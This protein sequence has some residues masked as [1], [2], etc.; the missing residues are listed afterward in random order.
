MPMLTELKVLM[1]F[2]LF[3][4]KSLLLLVKTARICDGIWDSFSKLP[5]LEKINQDA[6]FF[7]ENDPASNSIEEVYLA[8][9]GFYAIAIYRLSHA[10]TFRPTVVFQIDE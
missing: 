3:S 4:K 5:V 9:P 10:N 2:K 8:Y 6:N 1:N 7:L